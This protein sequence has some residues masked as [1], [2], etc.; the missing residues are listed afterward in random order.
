MKKS[1]YTRLGTLIKSILGVNDFSMLRKDI[2]KK[3]GKL[4]Y[5]KKY[6]VDDLV[7]CMIRMGMT[8]GRVVC[9]HASM[10]EFYNYNGTPEELITK[11]LDVITLEGTLIM[12][13]FVSYEKQNAIDY[14][15]DAKKDR[16]AAGCLAETFRNYPGVK[17]S[18]NVRHSICA[19]GKYAEMLTKGH[20]CCENCWDENSPW[21]K[22]TRL[23]ALVVNLGLSKNYIGTF[24][25]CVEGLLYKEHPYW[26]QFFNVRKT[27]RYYDDN[28]EICEYESIDGNIEQR[29]HEQTLI[30]RFD[31]SM[32][33]CMKL[34]NLLINVYESR[35]CIDKM[36]ELG[37][38]GI[39]MY[40]VPSSKQYKFE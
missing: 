32:H 17:R 8:P 35:P 16:T 10:K 25:H 30:S 3:I 36:I 5:H 22:M 18:I 14:V 33:R 19:I 20:E 13:A 24:D 9:I 6:S 23:N 2:R 28:E 38:K 15:F 40:Y 37:R 39:T 27:F 11:I 34:S 21:Y 7:E 26:A 12:P 4:I 1:I 31:S 29:S